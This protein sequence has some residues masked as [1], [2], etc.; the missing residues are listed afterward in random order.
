MSRSGQR[1][2]ER[3]RRLEEVRAEQRREDRRRRLVIGAAAG[4]SVLL[5][6]GGVWAAAGGSGSTATTGGT[7]SAGPSIV[8]LQTYTGLSRDHVTRPVAYPQTPP[9]GGAHAA[10]WQ[11]CGVYSAPVSNETAVH[12][13][14]H[15]ALWITYRPDLPAAQLAQIKKDVAGQPYALV[16]P[17][18]GLPAPVVAT[19]WG[20][21]LRLPNASDPRLNTFVATY[22]SA[23]QAPEPRGEC[24]GGTGTPSG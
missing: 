3:E 5:V 16:S 12:S 4:V 21:Q 23:E 13:L 24:T 10:V 11:N 8:G 19:V 14:E 7:P 17:Y 6:G 22:A 20:A 9:V 15:G 1:H 2:A 18:P